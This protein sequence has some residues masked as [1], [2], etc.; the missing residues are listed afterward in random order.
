MLNTGIYKNYVEKRGTALGQQ[1]VEI[2][3]VASDEAGLDEG[4]PTIATV[5]AKDFLNNPLLHQEVFGPYSLLVKC[6]DSA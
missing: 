3:A 1:E 2:I 5:A 6:T 4:T